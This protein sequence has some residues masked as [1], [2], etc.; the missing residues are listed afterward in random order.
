MSIWGT[1]KSFQYILYYQTRFLC[2]SQYNSIAYSFSWYFNKLAMNHKL[3][4]HWHQCPDPSLPHPQTYDRL[5]GIDNPGSPRC[6]LL[7]LMASGPF[8]LRFFIEVRVR[9][10]SPLIQCSWTDHYQYYCTNQGEW[11]IAMSW[12]GMGSQGNKIPI[13]F[14]YLE[15]SV[16]EIGPWRERRSILNAFELSVRHNG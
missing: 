16:N 4:T 13:K 15:T 3:K 1:D 10:K 9:R 2:Y 11:A 7:L 14:N 6:N 5:N 12:Q 8:H